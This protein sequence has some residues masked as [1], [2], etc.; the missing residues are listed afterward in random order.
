M[1]VVKSVWLS[2]T[3]A[4][5]P[6]RLC[7]SLWDKEQNPPRLMG[8][9]HCVSLFN[10]SW[11]IGNTGREGVC[12]GKLLRLREDWRL[13]FFFFSNF[14]HKMSSGL[15]M[16][17]VSLRLY[18]ISVLSEGD[19]LSSLGWLMAIVGGTCVCVWGG[20]VGGRHVGLNSMWH[21]W[22]VHSGIPG[23]RWQSSARLPE[24][25]ACRACVR[26]VGMVTENIPSLG[27]TFHKHWFCDL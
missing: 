26:L 4:D 11:I 2:H 14:I 13:F 19:D 1:L 16:A 24:A 21:S 25:P 15:L 7:L 20:C 8:R 5:S 18:W 22:G 6:F 9:D 12:G 23:A 10:L 27:Q 17:S 3:E